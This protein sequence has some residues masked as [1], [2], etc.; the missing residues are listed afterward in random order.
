MLLRHLLDGE[1]RSAFVSSPMSRVPVVDPNTNEELAVLG[2]S[3]LTTLLEDLA[4]YGLVGDVA[5]FVGSNGPSLGARVTAKGRQE[6][7]VP[8]LLTSS[9]RCPREMVSEALGRS[10]DLIAE[11]ADRC[12]SVA[13]WCAAIMLYGRWL[14]TMCLGIALERGVVSED[15]RVGLDAFLKG[16]RAA[17]VLANDDVARRALDLLGSFRNLAV[18]PRGW[19]TTRSELEAELRV[20]EL[21]TERDARTM[22]SLLDT[23]LMRLSTST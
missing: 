4:R 22:R 10:L 12:L 19:V 16:L 23:V 1:D 5:P 13:A 21:P 11:E 8:R 6:A 7:T 18:H 2:G 3:Y 14:E 17:G 9:L 15:Q 20:L